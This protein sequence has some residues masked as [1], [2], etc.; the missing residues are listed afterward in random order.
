MSNL[1]GSDTQAR[2]RPGW[3]ERVA[4]AASFAPRGTVALSDWA[5]KR[6]P[7]ASPIVPEIA[8]FG[9]CSDGP[10]GHG[11]FRVGDPLPQ[12]NSAVPGGEQNRSR[13]MAK[14]QA[15]H[16]AAGEPSY[17]NYYQ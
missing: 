11:T 7:A 3:G 4:D 2:I 15:H 8:R 12:C 10:R 13:L 5:P 1:G 9:L 14:R 16:D 17:T 6:E